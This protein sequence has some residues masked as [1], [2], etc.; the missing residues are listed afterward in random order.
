MN[1]EALFAKSGLWKWFDDQSTQLFGLLDRDGL[2]HKGIDYA[3]PYGTPVGV[4][5]GGK[6]VYK[7]HNNNS[8]NDRVVIQS[9]DGYWE[10][11]HIDSNVQVGDY[12]TTGDVVGTIDGLP[13]DMYS[14]GPHVHIQWSPRWISGKIW[15]SD[16]INPLPEIQKTKLAES[17][18]FPASFKAGGSQEINSV[19]ANTLSAPNDPQTA[20]TGWIDDITGSVGDAVAGTVQTTIENTLGNYANQLNDGIQR[21]MIILIILIVSLVAIGGGFFLLINR[22]PVKP[23]AGAITRGVL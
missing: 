9:S 10:Y 3:H 2:Q 23:V 7:D 13:V 6:V 1:P 5:A 17:Q 4:I 21:M 18:A 14:S 22:N 15:A 11:Q 12:L 16:W 19:N 20:P 8:L